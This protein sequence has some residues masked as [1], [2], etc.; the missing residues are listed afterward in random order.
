M[1]V[2]AD[3]SAE[4]RKEK[5]RP[6]ELQMRDF[7]RGWKEARH[8]ETEEVPVLDQ[9]GG[10]DFTLPDVRPWDFFMPVLC[11]QM[12]SL[13]DTSCCYASFTFFIFAIPPLA[14]FPS[15]FHNVNGVNK[16]DHVRKGRERGNGEKH[17]LFIKMDKLTTST[18]DAV[19]S[20]TR[21]TEQLIEEHILFL[22]IAFAL[23]AMWLTV[24]DHMYE[25]DDT[26]REALL[27]TVCHPRRR[28]ADAEMGTA[29]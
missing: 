18:C 24:C 29:G 10:F 17:G 20:L 27:V 1:E 28:R 13:L 9:A 8:P 12:P 22:N 16:V 5:T 7:A 23:T 14:F 11:G 4:V 3:G 25:G 2:I 15:Y 6:S 26:F 21:K 19:A